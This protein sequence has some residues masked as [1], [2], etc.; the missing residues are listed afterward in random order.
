MEVEAD[1]LAKVWAAEFFSTSREHTTVNNRRTQDGEDHAAARLLRPVSRS[2]GLRFS[3]NIDFAFLVIHEI[4]RESNLGW[5]ECDV[6]LSTSR[7]RCR[8]D[9]CQ[10]QELQCTGSLMP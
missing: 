4:G 10:Q 1:L 5:H 9:L 2:D 3:T 6:C 8:D 7:F